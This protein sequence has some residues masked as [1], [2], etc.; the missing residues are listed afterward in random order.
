MSSARLKLVPPEGEAPP[1]STSQKVRRLQAEARELAREQILSLQGAIAG[2]HALAE[3]VTGGG[4]AY[5]VGVR[6]LA[7]RMASEL[8]QYG[9]TLQAIVRK[10]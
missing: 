5:P 2:L 3:D 1:E 9:Q 8:E 6:E 4:D 10:R 7:R